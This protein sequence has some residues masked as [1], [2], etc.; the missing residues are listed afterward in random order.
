MMNASNQL[1]QQLPCQGKIMKILLGILAVIVLIIAGVY[2]FTSGLTGIAHE[3]LSAIKSGN[4]EAAYNTT[5]TAFQ[6]NTSL[7]KFK[8]Y[9]DQHPILKNYKSV[10]FTTRNIESGNGYIGGTIE[11]ES[12][13]NIN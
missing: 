10:R 8:N 5:S 12:G 2:Y 6:Q 13:N 7:E 3:Q 9:I 11:D 4:I 1:L